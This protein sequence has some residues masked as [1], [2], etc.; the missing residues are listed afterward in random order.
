MKFTKIPTNTFNHLQ[1]NAGFLTTE[2]TPATGTATAPMA[3]T[4]GGL[5]FTATPEFT[6]FGDDIDNC[7]K[8]TKELKRITGYEVTISG[9]MLTIDHTTCAKLLAAATVT[10]PESTGAPYKFE[11][12]RTLQ[13]SD[14]SDLWFVGDYSSD[15][16]DANGGFVAIKLINA[17]NTGGFQLTTTD[18][19]KGQFAFTFTGHTSIATPDAVPFELYLKETAD[20]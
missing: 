9:N 5:T 18:K 6:D 19:G 2:F 17:L 12:S 1:M 14:F 13:D 7:P 11:P 10:N 3:A 4:T 15:N 16:T 20:A 8:N